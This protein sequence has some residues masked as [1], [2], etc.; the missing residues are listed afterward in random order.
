ME[1]EMGRA[2]ITHGEKR[3]TYRKLVGRLEGAT[4]EGYIKWEDNIKMYE[5]MRWYGLN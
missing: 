4:K 5:K 2:C 3:N 1:N